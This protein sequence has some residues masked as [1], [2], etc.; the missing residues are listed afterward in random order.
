MTLFSCI[1]CSVINKKT[2]VFINL[3]YHGEIRANEV[4]RTMKSTDIQIQHL[5]GKAIS[6]YIHEM[7]CPAA[8]RDPDRPEARCAR[9][10]S[11]ERDLPFTQS[12][13]TI[14]RNVLTLFC[15]SC[16]HLVNKQASN[17]I[18]RTVKWEWG[19]V[20]PEW[21]TFSLQE[22]LSPIAVPMGNNRRPEMGAL[23]CDSAVVAPALCYV[24]LNPL[25]HLAMK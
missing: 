23:V 17:Q 15:T 3:H 12:E 25:V 20:G 2:T 1:V 18:P 14:P 7:P 8:E 22:W 16:L 11:W 5:A 9:G 21:G 13:T 4:T 19:T 24:T 10:R 6:L